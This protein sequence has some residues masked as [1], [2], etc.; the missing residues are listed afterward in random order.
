MTAVAPVLASNG[1]S[2][3]GECRPISRAGSGPS[4][5]LQRAAR[6]AGDAPTLLSHESPRAILQA[7]EPSFRQDRLWL[8]PT[9]IAFNL[10]GCGRAMLPAIC[11]SASGGRTLGGMVPAHPGDRTAAAFPGSGKARCLFR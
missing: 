11:H 7:R 5:S 1:R 2:A 3:I 8:S 4:P 6:A 9:S 10:R